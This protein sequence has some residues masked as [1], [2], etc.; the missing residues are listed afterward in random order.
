MPCINIQA[1]VPQVTAIVLSITPTLTQDRSTDEVYNFDVVFGT[2]SG[3]QPECML[4][5]DG[6]AVLT[7]TRAPNTTVRIPYVLPKDGQN[8][9]FCAD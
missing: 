6:N 1:G 8:H 7:F 9:T 2:G 5:V 4:K 3:P